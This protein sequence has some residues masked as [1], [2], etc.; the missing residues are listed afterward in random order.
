MSASELSAALAVSL[1]A[2]RSDAEIIAA[3]IR[4]ALEAYRLNRGRDAR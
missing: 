4:A 1:R 2:G 3:A